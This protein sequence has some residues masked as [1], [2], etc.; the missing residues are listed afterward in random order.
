M[1]T[2]RAEMVV[3]MSELPRAADALAAGAVIAV[4]TDTVYGLAA[5]VDR[6][7]A[8]RALFELKGRPERLAL[9][10]L[11][12]DEDQ[13]AAVAS[14]WPPA[15]RA[16]AGSFWPGALTVVVP[17]RD[18]LGPVLGGDGITVG[19][20][21]PGDAFVRALCG[22]AGP[23]AVTSAN[24]H[25]EPPCTTPLAVLDV[26]GSP[27]HEGV[28]AGVRTVPAGLAMVVDGGR[29]D[30]VPSTVVDCTVHPPR[31]VRAGSIALPE[32]MEALRGAGVIEDAVP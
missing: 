26:F 29:R 25:S 3:G 21:R 31:Q 15:A 1:S 4:P 13:V 9:P 24:R 23:L 30:G 19:V 16:L 5:R 27:R 17:V 7:N 2:Q 11:V 18:A 12:R 32:V 22:C 28:S 8:L 14:A 6:P 10:I 20:R